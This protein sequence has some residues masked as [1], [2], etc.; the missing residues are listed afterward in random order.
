MSSK[1]I[2]PLINYTGEKSVKKEQYYWADPCY[3]DFQAEP[4][5][6]DCGEEEKEIRCALFSTDLIY[7]EAKPDQVS[8]S[9]YVIISNGIHEG[10]LII[11]D[12]NEPFKWSVLQEN[13][14]KHGRAYK[15]GTLNGVQ[16]EFL[17]W[18]PYKELEAFKIDHCTTF[19]PH[20]SVLTSLDLGAGAVDTGE[21]NIYTGKLTLN[22]KF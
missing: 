8:D 22:L 15:S 9:G 14:H 21:Y 16:Q 10:N 12:S 1:A 5:E 20:A 17:S 6:Y 13:L 11:N 4:I 3:L 18:E 2:T 7:I 19:D